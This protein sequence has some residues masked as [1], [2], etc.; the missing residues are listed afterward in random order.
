MGAHKGS[1]MAFHV[2]RLMKHVLDYFSKS[3][4]TKTTSFLINIFTL[5]TYCIFYNVIY[6]QCFLE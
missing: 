2:F 1:G 3:T 5:Y 6:I 4:N